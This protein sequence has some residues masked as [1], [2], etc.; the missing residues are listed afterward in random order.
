M[1][2][3]KV[4]IRYNEIRHI[5]TEGLADVTASFLV[6]DLVESVCFRGWVLSRAVEEC[7]E[8]D[9]SNK[10]SLVPSSSST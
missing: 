9:E 2:L 5:I 1:S 8:S 7:N 6:N 4:E 10:L 3:D